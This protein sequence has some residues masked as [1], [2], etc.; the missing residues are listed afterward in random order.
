[1]NAD[2]ALLHSA[3]A[4]DLAG[5]AHDAL[6]RAASYLAARGG[7]ALQGRPER[8]ADL[9]AQRGALRSWWLASPQAEALAQDYAAFRQH[10]S[11]HFGG[12]GPQG[13]AP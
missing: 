9:Q 6:Y 7:P 12:S 8:L 13:E 3:L 10:W 5:D 2:A 4:R 11:P 1:M